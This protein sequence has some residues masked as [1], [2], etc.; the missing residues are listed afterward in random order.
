MEVVKGTAASVRYTV[1]VTGNK[2][3]VTT[4]HHAIFK[5]GGTTVLFDS[6]S[7]PVISEGDRLVVAGRMQGR[8][9]M[10]AEAYLN[11]SAG[12]RGD[13]GLRANFAGM[14]FA[15]LVAS[16]ALGWWLFEPILPWLPRLD[17]E[18]G[19]FVAGFGALFTIIG[20]FC[21]YKWL[22]IRAA[23]KLVLGR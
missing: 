12:I 3:G 15:F 21:L 6:G 2:D 13:S 16:A 9:V 10:L 8:G 4:R 20:F 11:N 14:L 17:G 7:P 18:M 19:W 22:R 23:V 5:V 1:H